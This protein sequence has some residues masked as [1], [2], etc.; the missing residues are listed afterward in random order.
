MKVMKV[1]DLL[2]YMRKLC[3]SDEVCNM[4]RN[5]SY[6]ATR[7]GE[8]PEAN[9]GNLVLL[10]I[11]PPADGLYDDLKR[12]ACIMLRVRAP[13]RVELKTKK[14]WQFHTNKLNRNFEDQ[15]MPITPR[16]QNRIDY[17]I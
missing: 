5:Y 11:V 14:C 4:R 7:E 1:Y 8:C 13:S 2:R 10:H 3:Q 17:A 6:G 15:A 9:I 16:M 12:V